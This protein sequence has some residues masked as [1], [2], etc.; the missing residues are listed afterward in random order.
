MRKFHPH[1][2]I[3]IF[4]NYSYHRNL[5]LYRRI[6]VGLSMSLFHYIVIKSDDDDHSPQIIVSVY[7]WLNKLCSLNKL[8]LLISTIYHRFYNTHRASLHASFDI[9]TE[10]AQ[11]ARANNPKPKCIQI[12]IKSTGKCEGTF[13]IDV[14]PLSSPV[15]TIKYISKHH[16]ALPK[17][18][19]KHTENW[20]P[21]D[22][23]ILR[24]QRE[25][26][27]RARVFDLSVATP[28][29]CVRIGFSNASSR[30]H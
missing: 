7:E 19:H 21:I 24:F 27:S 20:P 26:A 6:I 22:S 25:D 1:I 5:N 4:K 17:H 23:A 9:P 13:P 11:K 10:T 8:V 3:S 18:T 16:L 29:H 15:I 30:V 28:L 2:H 12:N 14:G